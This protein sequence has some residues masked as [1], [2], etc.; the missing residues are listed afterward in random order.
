MS[1]FPFLDVP[2]PFLA[3]TV[4][5]P[6]PPFPFQGVE[7]KKPFW[8]PRRLLWAAA[9]L[10]PVTTQVFDLT[11]AGFETAMEEA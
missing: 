9:L 3:G 11:A 5:V 2:V 4:D 8:T 7:V 6:V 1:P 10:W